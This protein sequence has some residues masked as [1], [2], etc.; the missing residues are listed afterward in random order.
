MKIIY[1]RLIP[2]GRRYAAINLFGILFVKYGIKTDSVLLNHERIHTAQ[3]RELAWIPFYIIYVIEWT[4]RLLQCRGNL[5]D[6]YMRISFER[7]AY[8]HQTDLSY[9]GRRRHFAQ[10]R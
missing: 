5:H 9:L 6:A 2:F 3:I 10:W 4:V 8:H 1:N 7:E